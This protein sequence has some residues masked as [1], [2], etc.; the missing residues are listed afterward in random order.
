MLLWAIK[1]VAEPAEALTAY[2]CQTSASQQLVLDTTAPAECPSAES[3]FL[4]VRDER[5]QLLKA[6][7]TWYVPVLQCAV[8]ITKVV[9]PCGFTS[10]TYASKTIMWEQ[11]FRTSNSACKDSFKQGFL[12]VEKRKVPVIPGATSRDKHFS[13]G[14]VSTSGSCT[15]DDFTT[16]GNSYKMSYEE[17]FLRIKIERTMAKLDRAKGQLTFDN[18][19]RGTYEDGSVFD[20][21]AGL[22]VWDAETPETCTHNIN[23]F[24]RGTAQVRPQINKPNRQGTIVMVGKNEAE[25][26]HLGFILGEPMKLCGRTCHRVTSLPGFTACFFKQGS[27]QLEELHF[28]PGLA[29]ADRDMNFLRLKSHA[30]ALFVDAELRNNDRFAQVVKGTC[31]VIRRTLQN[32]LQAISGVGNKHALLDLFGRGHLLTPAGPNVAYLTKC[33]AVEV[34]KADYDNC[35]AEVPVRVIPRNTTLLQDQPIRFMDAATNVLQRFPTRLTCSSATPVRWKLQGEW[36]CSTPKMLSCKKPS[37]LKPDVEAFKASSDFTKGIT[38][39]GL[40]SQSMREQ[41]Y[42]F[43]EEQAHRDA[44]IMSVTRNGLDNS[45]Y[46]LGSPVSQEDVKGWTDSV[47]EKMSPGWLFQVLGQSTQ[48]VLAVL[49]FGS[50]TWT[51]VTALARFIVEFARNGWDGGKTLGRACLGCCGVFM[52]PKNLIKAAVDNYFIQDQDLV[53]EEVPAPP[54]RRHL[55]GLPP[56]EEAKGDIPMGELEPKRLP[57]RRPVRIRRPF[58]LARLRPRRVE[59]H[60]PPRLP[61]APQQGSN[62][63]L[64]QDFDQEENNPQL[65]TD[66]MEGPYRA[67][68]YNL[69]DDAQRQYFNLHR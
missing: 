18:G 32:K 3:D 60:Q 41:V 62:L 8:F 63:T 42:L 35:T 7:G 19:V 44:V 30:D 52:L 29:A 69:E 17:T 67:Q 58:G 23:E 4:S 46:T 25:T 10:L 43:Q 9:T 68:P 51:L 48:F 22:M 20:N 5:L 59:V 57:V 53:R 56:Y 54:E 49:T 1:G 36:W 2:D 31:E 21:E 40:M 28:K 47:I 55:E 13:H 65:G 11:A 12:L 33:E 64:Y 38:S 26:R 27:A 15:N 34:Q 50:I 39:G 61:P 24:W 37:Q 16:A 66:H 45:E 14:S 6:E